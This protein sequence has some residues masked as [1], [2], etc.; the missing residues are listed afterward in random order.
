[1]RSW[2]RIEGALHS[3]RLV[4]RKKKMS[5]TI[6]IIGGVGLFLLGMTVMTVDLKGWPL[7]AAHSAEQRGGD[8]A[9]IVRLQKRA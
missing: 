3:T 7:G 8:T 6:S 5:M 2:L 4:V 9:R 1:M